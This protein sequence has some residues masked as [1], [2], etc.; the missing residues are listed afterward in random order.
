MALQKKFEKVSKLRNSET[1]VTSYFQ[2]LAVENT[3]RDDYE[4]V[5]ELSANVTLW[6]GLSDAFNQEPSLASQILHGPSTG[7]STGPKNLLGMVA[8]MELEKATEQLALA[9][10]KARFTAY[11]TA[12]NEGPDLYSPSEPDA[13]Q[14][15]DE[16]TQLVE[17][18]RNLEFER[19]LLPFISMASVPMDGPGGFFEA[20]QETLDRVMPETQAAPT[21]ESSD[22]IAMLKETKGA[23]LGAAAQF[24]STIENICNEIEKHSVDQNA[25]DAA[26]FEDYQKFYNERKQARLEETGDELQAKAMASADLAI[27]VAADLFG[28]YVGPN[29]DIC[30]EEADAD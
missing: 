28:A 15:I 11:E 20:A 6:Q 27:G 3:I 30:D 19:E 7:P 2:K 21:S 16:E 18:E 26:N 25:D 8:E 14:V 10:A 9:Q 1:K 23:M 13:G 4:Y 5:A 12:V 24:G 22:A 29:G 17:Q